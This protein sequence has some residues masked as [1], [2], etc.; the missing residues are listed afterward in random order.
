M[1]V[2][3]PSDIR[4]AASDLSNLELCNKLRL[5]NKGMSIRERKGDCQ[6]WVRGEGKHSLQNPPFTRVEQLFQGK[7]TWPPNPGEDN[8]QKQIKNNSN[9]SLRSKIVNSPDSLLPFVQ[10]P[11]PPSLLFPLRMGRVS[12]RQILEKKTVARRETP[13]LLSTSRISSSQILKLPKKAPRAL[14]EVRRNRGL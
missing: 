2:L 4:C 3:S 9:L 11:C 12:K 5:M 1:F 8:K 13:L 6:T 10:E 7:R 14:R